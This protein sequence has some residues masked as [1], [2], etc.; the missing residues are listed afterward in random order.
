MKAQRY[1][2]V[3]AMIDP[4]AAVASCPT[5]PPKG[6]CIPISISI[7]MPAR[8]HRDSDGALW[9]EVPALPGCVAG[10]ETL[11][12]LLANLKEAAEGWLLAKEDIETRGWPPA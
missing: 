6:G 12:E 7:E 3:P 1:R 5:V 9:A 4:A 8:I 10:G 11:D 2:R